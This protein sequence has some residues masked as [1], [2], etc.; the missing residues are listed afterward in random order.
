MDVQL[1]QANKE[2]PD[3]ITVLPLAV[4][5]AAK[6]T[7]QLGAASSPGIRLQTAE[8]D[9]L[10]EMPITSLPNRADEMLAFASE[11]ADWKLTLAA[12]RLAARVVAEVFNLVTIGDG[13]VG[14]SATIRYG[15]VNQGV[16]EFRIACRRIGECRVHRPEHPAQGTA[17]R[18][19]TIPF[20]TRS[21][22]ATRW[23]S[24]T[25]ISLTP[26]AARSTAAAHAVDVERETGSSPSR[27][28][29]VC[30]LNARRA[31]RTAA[32]RG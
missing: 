16:Q 13:L 9:G 26:R 19:W 31:R 22:A 6:V 11:Q 10:R 15:I 25:I 17:G 14:G 32:A 3:K 1:E 29:R 21:G 24:P 2:F 30:K 18:R 20:R 7:T 8:L 4:A 5:G 28:P 23:S 12:E 27:P